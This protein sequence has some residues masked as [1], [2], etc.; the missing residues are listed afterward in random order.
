MPLRSTAKAK[1]PSKKVASIRMSRMEAWPASRLQD[2]LLSG[3]VLVRFI[4]L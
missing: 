3:L 2:A 1:D 4:R